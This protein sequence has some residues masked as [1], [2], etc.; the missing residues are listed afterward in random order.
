[1]CDLSE[2]Q[3]QELSGCLADWMNRWT[4]PSLSF[5]SRDVNE[6]SAWVHTSSHPHGKHRPFSV[7]SSSCCSDPHPHP[8]Y[9]KVPAFLAFKHFFLSFFFFFLV[10]ISMTTCLKLSQPQT[11]CSSP[12][13]LLEGSAPSRCPVSFR[14]LGKTFPVFSGRH[15]HICEC[16]Y[17]PLE[18]TPTTGIGHPLSKS[19]R[20]KISVKE[21]TLSSPKWN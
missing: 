21:L 2:G 12:K 13:L 4:S 10:Q 6:V 18:L 17:R 14:A 5:L 15:L 9:L 20:I 1:M 7:A 19:P 8:T 16:F 3:S 11:L